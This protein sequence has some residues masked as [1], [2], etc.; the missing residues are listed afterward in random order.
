MARILF[1]LNLLHLV[2][3]GIMLL[4]LN[5][6]SQSTREDQMPNV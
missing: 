1:F 2:F 4:S 6:Q 5:I 3:L